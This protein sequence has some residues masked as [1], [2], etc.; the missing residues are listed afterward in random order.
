[1]SYIIS[2]TYKPNDGFILA[3]SASNGPGNTH[4]VEYMDGSNHM[5]MRNDSN[6]EEAMKKIFEDGL[7]KDY[8]KTKKR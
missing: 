4:E 5:Q 1:M 3:E 6:T 8:F 2:T 7:Q